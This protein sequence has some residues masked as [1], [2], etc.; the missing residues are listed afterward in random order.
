VSGKPAGDPA[1]PQQVPLRVAPNG[2]GMLRVGG[3]DTSRAREFGLRGGRTPQIIREGFRKNLPKTHARMRQT[4]REIGNL[5]ATRK[6]KHG[7]NYEKLLT[8]QE[9]LF[10]ALERLANFEAKYGVGT[11]ITETNTDGHDVIR[12]IREPLVRVSEN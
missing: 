6:E 10:N 12:V 2:R 4:V 8:D 9:R 3:I 11:T 7:E 5:I 1:A